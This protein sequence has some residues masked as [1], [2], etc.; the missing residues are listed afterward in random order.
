MSDGAILLLSQQIVSTS[1]LKPIV[2][3]ASMV[4]SYC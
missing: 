2:N 4:I 3:Q 1:Y